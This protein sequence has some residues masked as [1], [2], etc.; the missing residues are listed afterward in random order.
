MKNMKIIDPRTVPAFPYAERQKNLLYRAE[1]FKMRIIELDKGGELP[2]CE[3]RSYV[4]FSVISGEIEIRVD[5]QL[6]LLHEGNWLI[7][8]PALFSMKA[9]RASRLVGIQ[10]AKQKI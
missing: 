9:I 10:I 8:E 6:S 1:E 5:H 2:E 4:I 3:M 7:S